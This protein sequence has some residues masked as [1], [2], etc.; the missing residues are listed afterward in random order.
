MGKG[1]MKLH[2]AR[3]IARA[4]R[5]PKRKLEKATALLGAWAADRAT[6]D[7]IDSAGLR[8]PGWLADSSSGNKVSSF[9]FLGHG[10]ITTVI[11]PFTWKTVDIDGDELAIHIVD[12]FGKKFGVRRD[13]SRASSHQEIQPVIVQMEKWLRGQNAAIFL[14]RACD[15]WLRVF[16]TN[17]SE[18]GTFMDRRTGQ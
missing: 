5:T 16:R 1:E 7:F 18:T 9:T 15:L 12:R 11:L 2:V 13:F 3:E 10:G 17:S 14:R 6:V 8:F 4:S